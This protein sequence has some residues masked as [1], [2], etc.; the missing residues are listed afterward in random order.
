MTVSG[1]TG[2]Y[3]IHSNYSY[4]G[5][6][7]L[8]E[9]AD[10]AR[11]HG[12]RFV[13]LTEHDLGFDQE[14][15]DRYLFECSKYRKDVLL[16]PGMEYEVIHRGGIIHIGAVGLPDLVQRSVLDKGIEPLVEKIHEKGGIAVLHHPSN[17]R[18]LLNK[19]DLKSFDFIEVWNTKFDCDFAPNG[20]FLEWLKRTWCGSCLVSADIHEV[21]RFDRKRIPR[22]ELSLDP[23]R[24]ETSAI[25]DQL[26]NR[27][28][29]CLKGQWEFLPDGS[30]TSSRLIHRYLPEI[31]SVKKRIFRIARALVPEPYRK[32]VYK[33][34]NRAWIR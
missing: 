1:M 29:R 31:C 26:I 10:W 23:E 8:E 30:C 11:A 15:F 32:T 18:R 20:D 34:V 28:Y 25:V 16:V 13:L 6:N 5:T 33:L 7:S 19:D 21:A 12:I 22:I 17:I 4:D 3:H 24:L 2:I 9:I 14:K 27:M